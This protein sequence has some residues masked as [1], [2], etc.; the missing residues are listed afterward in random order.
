MYP[1]RNGRRFRPKKADSRV[2]SLAMFVAGINP[3]TDNPH[4]TNQSVQF[5]D[6]LN[7]LRTLFWSPDR[8]L[9]LTRRWFKTPAS[10]VLM[11]ATAL[12]E[13]ASTMDPQMTGR[14]RADLTVDLLMAD[15]FFY[16]PELN[17]TLALN[18]PLVVNN[19]GDENAYVN[20]KI[21]FNGE[22]LNPRI[23]NSS[24]TRDN[25]VQVST[26]I[27]SSD[28]VTLDIGEFTA[29]R[30]FDGDNV[31]GT[32]LHRGYESWFLLKPGNN[33]LTLTAQGASS[34]NAKITFK[35]PYL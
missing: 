7:A 12:C 35:P 15:P 22:L 30:L 8:Q 20:M 4:A 11:T 16:G 29:N 26:I 25:F 19:P 10:P 32:V 6:N 1:F 9:T 31:A 14:T 2:I 34:G 23:T 24:D 5:N 21:E 33:T 18:T 3:A 17:S 27:Q 13:L 28:K